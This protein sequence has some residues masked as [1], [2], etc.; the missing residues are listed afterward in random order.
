[1]F[2]N[3]KKFMLKRLIQ[4]IKQNNRFV[5]TFI[6]VLTAIFWYLN[7]SFWGNLFLLNLLFFSV[8]FFLNSLWL[9][10]ILGHYGFEREIEFI[11]GVFC[12]FYLISFGLAVPIVAYKITPLCLFVWLLFLTLVISFF[13][14]GKKENDQSLVEKIETK[15]GNRVGFKLYSLL[16]F[17]GIGCLFLLF[18]SRTGEDIRSPWQVLHPFYIYFW[19]TI[20]FILG[21][22]AFSKISLK[23]FL[24]IIIIISAIFH[25][26]LIVPYQ[27]GFGGDKWR[28]LGAEGWLIRGQVYEPAL[29][30]QNVS[31]QQ[32]GPFKI[33]QVLIVG[34]KT[35]YANMWGAVIA[36]SWLLKTHI[37]TIDLLLGWFLF[38]FFLPFLLLKIGLF[39]SRQKEFLCLFL[40]M[41]FCFY[42]FQAYG[43]ITLPSTFALLPFLLA[44]IFI[45]QYLSEDHFSK[46]TF[47]FLIFL[48]PFL[49]F[50]YLVY[51][52]VYL[53]ILVLA[54]LIK[55]L[56]FKRGL[57]MPL[58][59]IFFLI[60]LFL[61]PLMETYNHYS[62]LKQESS[63]KSQIGKM[64]TEFSLKL[65]SSQ[66]IF[67]RIY[68]LEQ[69]NW[70]YAS[71]NQNLSRSEFLKILPWSYILTPLVW[72]LV[73]FSLTQFKKLK[74]SN[75]AWL[76]ILMLIIVFVNQMLSSY[77][78]EG[79]HLLT[80]RLVVFT[81]FLFFLPLSWG[82]YCLIQQA[83]KFFSKKTM[84]F[85]LILFL[86]LLST[87]VYAS[88]PKFQTVTADEVGAAER[89][90]QELKKE[91][92]QNYCVLA[93]TWPLL[94]LEGVSG[95]E[96]VTG[97]FP[98]Y[99]EYRQPERVQLFENMNK[100]PS[101]RYLEKALEITKA[102]QCYFMTEER[103]VYFDRRQEIIKQIDELLGEH[104][105]FGE[106][107]IW[108]YK[109]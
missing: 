26:Y 34:N 89:V 96:I 54:V 5:F 80:K 51:L 55:N 28:H 87:T 64:L 48:I 42:P 11:F 68:S 56:K 79:N 99:Y 45:L 109:P 9:G 52:I 60:S 23:K 12:L 104:D 82:V 67:P 85:T 1:M 107:M 47:Y 6:S 108:K 59:I 61:M 57:I 72:F 36:L 7:F 30:G 71:I 38:S 53:E 20:I 46:G 93:N 40:M 95:M 66:P 74:N 19:L 37:F 100:N 63:F 88:G 29:F 78:M 92:K 24:F 8:Y 18:Y 70:L 94:A 69:D 97:G 15:E 31:Y 27:A 39:F 105:N 43:S 90:W 2:V 91:P 13:S 98:Y 49:Y 25:L 84:I 102:E 106:V 16:F 33:P 4:T 50:N 103:W 75:S 22:L 41:P 83:Q 86:S 21:W 3:W 32:F 17:L 62:W 77:L 10:K 76:L 14:K 44:L 58:L 101:I 35:S 81:S 73:F 65:V